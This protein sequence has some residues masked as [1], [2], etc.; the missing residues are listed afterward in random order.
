MPPIVIAAGIGGLL[1]IGGAVISSK[2]AKSAAETQAQAAADASSVQKEMFE[3]NRADLAPWREAGELSL[4]RLQTLLGL[5]G[6][7]TAEGYG[8]LT[9]P[10]QSFTPPNMIDDPSYQFRLSEGLKGIERSAA[11]KTGTL[12]GAAV[13]DMARFNQDYASGEYANTWNRGLNAWNAN[14]AN[15]YTGQANQFNRM[16]SLA[17]MGENAAGQTANLGS[18]TA[19]Q[20]G[21]NIIGA[22]NATAAGQVG[23]AN[24]WSG[25]LGNLG[26]NLQNMILLQQMLSKSGYQI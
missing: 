5:T 11:A 16:Q 1:G 18:A 21:Q 25:T 13:K 7:T 2:G 14:Q 4:D 20:I 15:Y 22:G 26:S 6:D 17:G 12:S 8:S 23:S 19:N 24:A 10:Y 3:E 9:T